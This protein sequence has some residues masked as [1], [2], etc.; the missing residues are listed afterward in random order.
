M[1]GSQALV[2]LIALAGLFPS[3]TAATELLG[4]PNWTTVKQDNIDPQIAVGPNHVVITQNTMVY[5]HRKPAR[6]SRPR[7]RWTCSSQC[8]I[9]RCRRT[10]TT[11]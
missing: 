4:G 1:T 8:G 3:S 6:W 9:P 2:A 11:A 7:A 5:F 10:S